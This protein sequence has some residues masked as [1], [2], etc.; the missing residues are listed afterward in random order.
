MNIEYEVKFMAIERDDIQEKLKSIGAD[1]KHD[2]IMMRRLVYENPL[3]KNSYLR[4]RD[5]W[6]KITLTLKEVIATNHIEGVKE[7]EV[8][9]SDFDSMKMIVS[10]LGM[11]MKSYQETYRE[12]RYKDGVQI[13]IDERPGLKP[14]I[15]IEAENEEKVK[16]F[17]KILWFDYE[18]G[19]FGTVS[20][21]Y[22]LELGIKPSVIN[23]MS[24]ITFEEPPQLY[25]S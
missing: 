10:K 14:F 17:V 25:I 1:K 9:I 16:E 7:I 22:Q 15:E 5:E 21:I 24:K 23:Y 6:H 13:T 3:N 18:K 2:N 20:D 19:V 8:E 4:V 12:T 11:E